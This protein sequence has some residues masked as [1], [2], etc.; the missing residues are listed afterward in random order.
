[1]NALIAELEKELKGK[2]IVKQ[3]QYLTSRGKAFLICLMAL[4][5]IWI[6]MALLT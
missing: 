6:A 3:L 5:Q 2:E 4:V 1:M